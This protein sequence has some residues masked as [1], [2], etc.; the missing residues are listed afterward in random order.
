MY[1]LIAYWPRL[2]WV[3]IVRNATPSPIRTRAPPYTVDNGFANRLVTQATTTATEVAAPSTKMGM[4]V[5]TV[6]FRDRSPRSSRHRI[7]S[8][9]THVTLNAPNKPNAYRSPRKVVL[10]PVRNTT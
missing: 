2:A 6:G 3:Q 9:L 1:G 7:T 10:A 5:R 4:L 8:R